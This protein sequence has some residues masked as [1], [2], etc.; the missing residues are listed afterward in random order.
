MSLVVL[1]DEEIRGLIEALTRDEAEALSFAL[2][3]ALHEYSTGTQSIEAGLIHQ[4]NRTS[5]HSNITN[6]TTLF[7]PSCSQLGHGVKGESPFIFALLSLLSPAYVL[8]DT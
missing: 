6:A 3:C 4:P 1:S 8:Q 7:M 2:K 5:I